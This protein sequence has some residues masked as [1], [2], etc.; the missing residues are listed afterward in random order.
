MTATTSIW[1]SLGSTVEGCEVGVPG[2]RAGAQAVSF[3]VGNES[4]ICMKVESVPLKEGLANETMIIEWKRGLRDAKN[5][6]CKN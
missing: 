6:C 3:F 4:C 5:D 2:V 1:L